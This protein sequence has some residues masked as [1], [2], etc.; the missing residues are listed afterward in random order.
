MNVKKQILTL[1][2]LFSMTHAAQATPIYVNFMPGFPVSYAD[3]N[4]GVRVKTGSKFSLGLELTRPF[5][6]FP[7]SVGVFYEGYFGGDYGALPLNHNGVCLY[8]YPF[9]HTN[10]RHNLDGQV[11]VSQKRI[12]PFIR[13]ATG[14]SFFNFRDGDAIQFGA[15]AINYQV[16]LGV[17]YPATESIIGGLQANYLTTFGG[18]SADPE[19]VTIGTTGF[20]FSA[21]MTLIWD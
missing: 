4:T 8:Y 9:G 12:A 10:I 3:I 15:S 19:P 13:M 21:R 14:L 6:S 11:E 17:D 20:T 7:I 2:A 18:I 1:A 5:I 16:A